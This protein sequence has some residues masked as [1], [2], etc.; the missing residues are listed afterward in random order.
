MEMTPTI[1]TFD[2][3]DEGIARIQSEGIEWM[4]GQNDAF[5]TAMFRH[6]FPESDLKKP[7]DNIDK[8][9]KTTRDHIILLLKK[10]GLR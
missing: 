3:I 4:D 5:W 1:V 6:F 8:I 7:Y 9:K 2:Q 10:D